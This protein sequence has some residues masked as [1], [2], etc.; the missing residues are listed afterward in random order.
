MLFRLYVI[1]QM[2]QEMLFI[3]ISVEW[4]QQRTPRLRFDLGYYVLL[5]WMYLPFPLFK[6]HGSVTPSVLPSNI[7]V[8]K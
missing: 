7:V 4:G 5:F 6:Q 3:F 2:R 1:F 8:R